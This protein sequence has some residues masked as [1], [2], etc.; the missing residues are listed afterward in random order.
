[1]MQKREVGYDNVD[2]PSEYSYYDDDD[3]TATTT[4]NKNDDE[5]KNDDSDFHPAH[6]NICKDY[7]HPPPPR[8]VVIFDQQT[9]HHS[10]RRSS[11]KGESTTTLSTFL[12]SGGAGGGGYDSSSSSSSA[13]LFQRLLRY[14]N[15]MSV[16]QFLDPMS[17]FRLGITCGMVRE[18]VKRKFEMFAMEHV[19]KQKFEIFAMERGIM[20]RSDDHAKSLFV[21]YLVASQY[22][23]KLQQRLL[24]PRGL[25]GYP[26]LRTSV[27]YNPHYFEFYVRLST[28]AVDDDNIDRQKKRSKLV[29]LFEGFHPYQNQRKRFALR[30]RTTCKRITVLS[31][32]VNMRRLF[33][34]ILAFPKGRMLRRDET[35]YLVIST[36]V[37]SLSCGGR[38]SQLI[39]SSAGKKINENI[40]KKK[41]W[42]KKEVKY[43][44]G[45]AFILIKKNNNNE[46]ESILGF[47]L[48][49]CANEKK[50]SDIRL[51]PFENH[52]LWSS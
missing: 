43:H 27:F 23:R 3:T 36:V 48:C 47:D 12:S 38:F 14:D 13:P 28:M 5:H 20:L 2:D 1:M 37:P 39:T 7:H 24:L 11:S 32:D 9:D 26:A 45:N 51:N 22:S 25:A 33:A 44:I 50:I 17:C 52:T 29:V 21:R 41:K 15:I 30:F 4:F 19:V 46:K 18:P 6:K 16:L 49:I 8:E 35:P 10:T 42:E 40:Q 34:T 31:D